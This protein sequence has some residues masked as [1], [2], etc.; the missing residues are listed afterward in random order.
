MAGVILDDILGE[1]GPLSVHMEGHRHRLW[2]LINSRHGYQKNSDMVANKDDEERPA[3]IPSLGPRMA[4]Y[5][6]RAC[7][8]YL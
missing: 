7:P 8:S 5:R 4:P 1:W 6:I 3:L 2:R